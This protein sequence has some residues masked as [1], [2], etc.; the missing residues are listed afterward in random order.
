MGRSPKEELR[1][2]L[3]PPLMIQLAAR[4]QSEAL[5]QPHSNYGF[6]GLRMLNQPQHTPPLLQTTPDVAHGRQNRTLRN[7]ILEFQQNQ[8]FY[9]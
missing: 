4:H 1:R 5:R 2:D 6:L 9:S 7:R 8:F 3:P